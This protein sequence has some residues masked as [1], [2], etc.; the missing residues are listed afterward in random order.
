MR[1]VLLV[2]LLVVK[3]RCDVQ[4][5]VDRVTGEYR[6][7]VGDQVWLRSSGTAL[8]ADERWYSSDDGSLPLI[9]TRLARGTDPYTWVNGTRHN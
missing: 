5:S 6:V 1:L 7:S 4:V 8:Y 3:C 2:V 9:D